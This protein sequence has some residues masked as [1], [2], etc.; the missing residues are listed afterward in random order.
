MQPDRIAHQ[1]QYLGLVENV[2]VRRAGF[3]YRATFSEFLRRYAL[4]SAV[5]WP[6]GIRFGEGEASTAVRALLVDARP[7]EWPHL[8]EPLPTIELSDD[9]FELGHTKVFVK[10]PKTLFMLERA[11][12]IALHALVGACSAALWR[13]GCNASSTK[14][15]APAAELRSRRPADHTRLARAFSDSKVGRPATESSLP[16][17][18][19]NIATKPRGPFGCSESIAPTAQWLR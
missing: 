8:P 6:S 2:R 12:A 15:A 1:V 14:D 5:T 7:C 4:L 11:R 9:D 3:C 17:C 16:R 10:N 18:A 19:G 13:S